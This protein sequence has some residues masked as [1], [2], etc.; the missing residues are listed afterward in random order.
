MREHTFKTILTQK[1][2]D[3]MENWDPTTNPSWNFVPLRLGT[4]LPTYCDFMQ[5][6]TQEI[7][8]AT[9]TQAEKNEKL[10]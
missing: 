4:T 9:N 5:K 2:K 10:G 1:T 7:V 8:F 3:S 6:L